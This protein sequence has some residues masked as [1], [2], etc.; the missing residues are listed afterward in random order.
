MRIA[1]VQ[2][3]RAQPPIVLFAKH[4]LVP[5]ART[6]IVWHSANSTTRSCM[7]CFVPFSCYKFTSRGSLRLARP[8]MHSSQALNLKSLSFTFD[9]P[10]G[11]NNERFNERRKRH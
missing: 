1:A 8:L 3:R 4:K 5:A 7:F 10:F 2:A 6:E 9:S 11:A